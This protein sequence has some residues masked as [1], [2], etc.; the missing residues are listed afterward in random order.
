MLNNGERLNYAFGL[1]VDAYKGLRTIQHAGGWA[2]YRSDFTQFPE[3]KLS[4][5]CLANLSNI[6]PWNLTV[7]VAEIYLAN[8]FTQ[9]EKPTGQKVAKFIDLPPRHIDRLTSPYYDQKRRNI[10]KLLVKDGKLVGEGFGLDFPLAAI[11]PTQLQALDTPFEIEMEFDELQQENVQSIIVKLGGGK[12]RE[13]QKLASPPLPLAQ[14][15]DYVGS[16][17]SDELNSFQKILLD[18]E[19]LYFRRGYSS[20]EALQPVAQDFFQAGELHFQF[21]RDEHNQICA[22]KLSAERVKPIRFNLSS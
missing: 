11:S 15:A 18:G 10:L 1:W 16:Y 3:Q 7:Q 22:F 13:F 9:E 4:V 19:Q 21:E 12:P 14:W 6:M 20:A 2:G 8:L 5:I 17:H